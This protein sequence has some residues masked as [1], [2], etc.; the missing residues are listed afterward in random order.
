MAI[1]RLTVQADSAGE[2]W[3]GRL[4]GVGASAGEV[5]HHTDPQRGAVG[6]RGHTIC[7]GKHHDKGGTLT[8]WSYI[9]LH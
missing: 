5:K 7:T 9:T 4:A 3:W 6:Q 2:G 1:D 8:T